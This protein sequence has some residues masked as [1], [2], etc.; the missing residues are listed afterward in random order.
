[1]SGVY[2]D[3]LQANCVITGSF[4]RNY[5][6]IDTSH[7]FQK[8]ISENQCK[9]IRKRVDHFEYGKNYMNLSY[10]IYALNI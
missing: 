4:N 1:M 5:Y 2:G 3:K 10:N 8:V 7:N 9:K 6:E